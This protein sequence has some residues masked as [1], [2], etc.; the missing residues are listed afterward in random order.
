[1]RAIGTGFAAVHQRAGEPKCGTVGT[2]AV[3]V[4]RGGGTPSRPNAAH[5]ASRRP[6]RL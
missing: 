5:M 2:A 1:M 3:V 4:V 6:G